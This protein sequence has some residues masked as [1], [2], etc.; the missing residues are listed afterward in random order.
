MN[1]EE[2]LKMMIESK[3]GNVKAFSEIVGVPY[4]TIRTMLANGLGKAGVDNVLK[5]CRGLDIDPKQL[6]ED[7]E[8]DD[9]S[10]S[11]MAKLV[12]LE[13]PR[14][15]KVYN[16]TEAQLHEQNNKVVPLVGTTAANPNELSYGDINMEDPIEI[17]VPK[18][19]ECALV[20]KGDSMEPEYQNGDIVFYKSQPAVENG[21]MAIVEIDG[22]GVTLKKVYYNY[23]DDKVVLRSLNGKYEDRELEPERVRILGKVVK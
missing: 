2:F 18:K 4:T 7:F 3:F 1:R 14:K 6:S 12:S 11:T 10:A 19:A 20:V 15:I 5:I 21:E 9:I 23:D 17:N 8:I 16:F 13:R 22:D